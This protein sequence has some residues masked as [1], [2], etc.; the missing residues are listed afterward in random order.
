MTAPKLTLE[1]ET[2]PKPK[3]PAFSLRRYAVLLAAVWTGSLIIFLVASF[4]REHPAALK[5]APT[6]AGSQKFLL[7][8]PEQILTRINPAH[9]DKP[10]QGTAPLQAVSHQRLGTIWLHQGIL[11]LLG[12]AGIG[13]FYL[14]LYD[15]TI[16]SVLLF[17]VQ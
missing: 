3:A 13:Y 2:S 8:S 7:T 9:L 12:L 16:P 17:S 4:S 11:W 10:S 6:A 5:I 15:S 14:R 1:P